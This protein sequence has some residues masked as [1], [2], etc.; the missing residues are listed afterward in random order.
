[1][2]PAFTLPS[3]AKINLYLR[4]L[5]KRKDGFHE[6]FTVFQTVSLHDTFHFSE[7]DDLVLSCSDPRIAV[8]ED[9]LI[10][11]AARALQGRY[12][13]TRGATIH[14]EKR[15]PSPGGLGGGSSNAAVTLIALCR[16]WQLPPADAEIQ[17]I[18]KELG[19]D[20]TFF[21]YG[22]TAAGL[23]RGEKIERMPDVTADNVLIVT[24]DVAVPTGEAFASVGADRLTN[25]DPNRILGVCRLEAKSL[26]LHHSVL[27]NDFEASVFSSYPETMRVKETLLKLGSVNAAL[28]GSGASVFAIF[29]KTETRQAAQKA[30]ERESTWRKFAVA[31][32]SRDQY[33]EMLH[34]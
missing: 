2:R 27:I 15:I 28:C 30:L 6:L 34:L 7:G 13:L 26:D 14:L 33:R 24:P 10:M 4:I 18:A 25:D 29:D 12:G 22:G 1:M 21:L 11:R 5:G 3:F 17:S 16:L 19:S 9:N 32:V 20:V 23:G 8:R 31:T